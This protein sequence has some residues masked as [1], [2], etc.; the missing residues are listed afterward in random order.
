MAAG[1]ACYCLKASCEKLWPIDGR[2]GDNQK[3]RPYACLRI[4]GANV[5]GAWRYRLDASHDVA[6]LVEPK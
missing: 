2:D 6:G 1:E 4:N 5:D 3:G